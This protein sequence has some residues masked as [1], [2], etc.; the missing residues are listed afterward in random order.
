[1][2]FTVAGLLFVQF[3]RRSFEENHRWQVWYLKLCFSH[4]ACQLWEATRHLFMLRINRVFGVPSAGGFMWCAPSLWPRLV[5]LTRWSESRWTWRPSL[6]PGRVWWVKTDGWND[7]PPRLKKREISV[8]VHCVFIPWFRSL[9]RLHLHWFAPLCMFFFF[10]LPFVC[11]FFF[12][13]S[14]FAHVVVSLIF[15]CCFQLF[16]LSV[17][18]W[19]FVC[20]STF[21]ILFFRLIYCFNN[22]FVFFPIGLLILFV[23]LISFFFY[24]FVCVFILFCSLFSLFC[25]CSFTLDLLFVLF[26]FSFVGPSF[27][28]VFLSFY[29]VI[30]ILLFFT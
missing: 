25:L 6:T 2:L 18:Y 13:H 14:C 20:L 3:K 10:I 26:I 30:F 8:F 21:F 24:P 9:A 1:M 29:L 23:L 22:L 11:L 15:Y 19:P 16:V 4:I 12:L 28:F 7:N 17:S 27:V 5:S